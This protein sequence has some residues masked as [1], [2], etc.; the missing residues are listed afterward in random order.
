MSSIRPLPR[1]AAMFLT[2]GH[3][4]PVELLTSQALGAA[5]PSTRPPVD[6]WECP[7]DTGRQ[8]GLSPATGLLR[9]LPPES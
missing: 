6:E 8:L 7:L 5:E 1:L 9:L 2:E 3:R 4:I